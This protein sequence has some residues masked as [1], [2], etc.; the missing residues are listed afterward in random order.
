[1]PE[2]QPTAP[3]SRDDSHELDARFAVELYD[4]GFPVRFATRHAIGGEYMQK[5]EFVPASC[6]PS[7]ALRAK[8]TRP[9]GRWD[10]TRDGGVA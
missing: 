6:R 7:S 3:P 10:M 2:Q 8:A 5:G 9:G 1:M 4:H